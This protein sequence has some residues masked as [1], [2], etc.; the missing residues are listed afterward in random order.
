MY[1]L[2]ESF[3]ADALACGQ[4]YYRDTSLQPEKLAAAYA[5]YRNAAAGTKLSNLEGEA[6][7]FGVTIVG[8]LA[9]KA[10][11]GSWVPA[12]ES[13]PS[14]DEIMKE[15]LKTLDDATGASGSI[16]NAANWSLLANDAW[17]LGGIHARTEFHFASPLR[18]EN[19]WDEGKG[20][21]TV[22]AR[23]AIGITSFGY[24]IIRPV[25]QL[26]AVAVCDDEG[27]AAAASLVAYRDEVL[28]RQTADELRRFYETLP[29]AVKQY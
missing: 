20:R 16:L 18:W 5:I 13:F 11:D 25:P 6:V 23:E 22:T 2:L 29:E 26:E 7:D 27:R 21:I 14:I 9:L 10:D 1:E 28:K 4:D 24:R 15:N 19:L 17:L 8:R 12:D 3:R